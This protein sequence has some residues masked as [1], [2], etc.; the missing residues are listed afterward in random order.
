M[1]ALADRDRLPACLTTPPAR[2]GG[3]A[4][5]FVLVAQLDRASAS[6]A[7]GWRFE[8]S[9]GHCSKSCRTLK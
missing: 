2:A 7:E 3:L 1:T 4:V 5:A 8:S 6:E 9:R